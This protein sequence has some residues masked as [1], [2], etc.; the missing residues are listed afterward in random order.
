MPRRNQF[1]TP[2]RRMT[3][4]EAFWYQ[5]GKV[6]RVLQYNSAVSKA[7]SDAAKAACGGY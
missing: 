5:V 4:L 1:S 3:R 7:C 6:A 2:I